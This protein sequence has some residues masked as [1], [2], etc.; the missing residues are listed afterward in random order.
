MFSWDS[1]RTVYMYDTLQYMY[2]V[3]TGKQ[4]SFGTVDIIA[5]IQGRPQPI[6]NKIGLKNQTGDHQQSAHIITALYPTLDRVLAL[7]LYRHLV[8]KVWF[9]FDISPKMS[10]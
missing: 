2:I 6:F 10:Q 9:W 8:Q 7:N 3:Y 4:Q 1:K 5:N